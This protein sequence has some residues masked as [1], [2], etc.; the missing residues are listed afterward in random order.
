M[1][2]IIPKDNFTANFQITSG[3][4]ISIPTDGNFPL[5]KCFKFSKVTGAA[6]VFHQYYRTLAFCRGFKRRLKVIT[7]CNTKHTGHTDSS[8]GDIQ[9]REQSIFVEC[10]KGCHT[11]QTDIYDIKR[12]I[13][14]IHRHAERKRQPQ[15]SGRYDDRIPV[16]YYSHVIAGHKIDI[17]SQRVD[18]SHHTATCDCG[19]GHRTVRDALGIQAVRCRSQLNARLQLAAAV[20]CDAQPVLLVKKE[21]QR[22]AA[23]KYDAKNSVGDRDAL[24]LFPHQRAA[25]GGFIKLEGQTVGAIGDCCPRSVGQNALVAQGFGDLGIDQPRHKHN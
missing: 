19:S 3:D 5:R 23:A 17:F 18:A 6:F 1:F 20:H 9:N 24:G 12:P 14:F 8:L 22:C 4:N 7:F 25:G 21:V 11:S 16:I 10:L 15:A 2:R 13:R